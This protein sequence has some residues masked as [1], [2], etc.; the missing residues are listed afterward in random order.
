M[1]FTLYTYL[2]PYII[3]AKI[4]IRSRESSCFHEEYIF[5]FFIDVYNDY[6]TTI[7][8]DEYLLVDPTAMLF[9]RSNVRALIECISFCNAIRECKSLNYIESGMICEAF[10]TSVGQEVPL[11]GS[12]Y[13]TQP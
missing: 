1:L 3:N 13:I 11:E 10:S 2:S 7:H 6:S 5:Y 9:Q 4:N 8:N 12:V